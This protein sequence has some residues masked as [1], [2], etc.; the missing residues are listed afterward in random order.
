MGFAPKT[1]WLGVAMTAAWAGL[2]FS[3]GWLFV[4]LIVVAGSLFLLLGPAVVDVVTGRPSSRD[5]R[6][7]LLL[8]LACAIITVGG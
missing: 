6:L 3:P 2:Y 1:H 8:Y 5:R 7:L 4:L